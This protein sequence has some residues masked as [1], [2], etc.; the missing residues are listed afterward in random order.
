M[1]FVCT[2]LAK[3]F[4]LSQKKSMNTSPITSQIAPEII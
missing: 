3:E 2:I 1:F 4:V